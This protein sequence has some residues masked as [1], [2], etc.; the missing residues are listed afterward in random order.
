MINASFIPAHRI[1]LTRIRRLV[2]AWGV[3]LACYTVML[4]VVLP[5]TRIAM[6]LPDTN[7]EEAH[8]RALAR[9]KAAQTERATL[10][11]KLTDVNKRI[12]AAETAGNHPD[13][14]LLL[15]ALARTRGSDAV[16]TRIALNVSR[17]QAPATKDTKAREPSKA[18]QELKVTLAGSAVNPGKVFELAQRIEQLGVFH[19]VHTWTSAAANASSVDSVSTAFELEALASETTEA[20][21]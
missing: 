18:P 1:R 11:A 7:N 13:Y 12:D 8:Q 4:I 21:P 3:A 10:Q 6:A 14:S 5:V 9:V 17:A 20:A 15:N 2:R 16:F 19:R